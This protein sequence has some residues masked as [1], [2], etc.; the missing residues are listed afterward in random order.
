[1]ANKIIHTILHGIN[2]PKVEHQGEIVV[3]GLGRFGSSLAHTLVDMG[4]EVLGVDFSDDKV[5]EHAGALTHV[6][7]ADTTSERSLRQIGAADAMTV[8]VCIGTDIESSVLTTTALVD[9]GVSNIWAKAI[10]D[11]HGRI[12]QRVGAHHVVF[13]EAEMGN[14][15]AHLVTGNMLE[16]MALDDDFVIAEL[17]AP[18]ELVGAQLGESNLRARYKVTVVCVKPSGGQFS[19]ADRTTVLRET[20]LIVIAGHRADVERFTD[21]KR[22]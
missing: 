6:V 5:Q 16:Y 17:I 14:R 9:L 12:L 4:Y 7:Q 8:V 3:I 19:Y 2:Q 1:V 22:R 21:R 18:D 11:A 15:V 13:P 10:T 20:D